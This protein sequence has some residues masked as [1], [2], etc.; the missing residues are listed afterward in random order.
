MF[1]LQSNKKVWVVPYSNIEEIN[2]LHTIELGLIADISFIGENGDREVRRID[3]ITYKKIEEVQVEAFY[4]GEYV[5][6]VVM[7]MPLD[8]FFCN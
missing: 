4:D 7:Y 5:T 1:K 2:F 8:K 6:R 3:E